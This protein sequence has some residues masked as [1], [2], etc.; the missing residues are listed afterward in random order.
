MIQINLLPVREITRRIK[1]KKQI[2]AFLVL[3]FLTLAALGGFAYVQNTWIKDRQKTIASLTKEKQKYAKILARIKKME[4]EQKM[5]ERRIAVIKKLKASSSLTV[6]ALDEVAKLTPPK[7]M[8]LTNFSQS[9]GGVKIT[10]MAL[11]NRTIAKYMD[12]LKTSPYINGVTLA[13]SA[14]KGFAGRNLKAFSIS[15]SVAVPSEK[16]TSQKK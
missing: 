8:W 4:E 6:H 14:L 2:T 10:G 16:K 12:D 15:C 1:A 5:L 3:F 9:G 7:R 11:D 13:S